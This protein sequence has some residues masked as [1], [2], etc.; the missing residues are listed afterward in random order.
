MA[1]LHEREVYITPA[2]NDAGKNVCQPQGAYLMVLVKC[3]LRV[4]KQLARTKK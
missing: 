3:I 2:I 4:N 1:V